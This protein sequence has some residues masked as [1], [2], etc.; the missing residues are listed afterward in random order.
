MSAPVALSNPINTLYDSSY[1]YATSV[2]ALGAAGGFTMERGFDTIKFRA[3][4]AIPRYDVTD[5]VQILFDVATFNAKLGLVKNAANTTITTTTWDPVADCFKS[6]GLEVSGVTLSAAELRSG[7]NA[8]GK[9]VVS[10]GKYATLYSDYKNYV[11]SYFGFDGGFSSLFTA[12]I[13]TN[14]FC[15]LYRKQNDILF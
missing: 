15:I 1:V 3:A 12:V 8:N 13:K 6:G 11:T 4:D 9:Q 14:F 5:A 2:Y 7:L 10:V